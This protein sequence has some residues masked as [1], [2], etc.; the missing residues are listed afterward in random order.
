MPIPQEQLFD[1]V[2]PALLSL[3]S[4]VFIFNKDVD[5]RAVLNKIDRNTAT[6][7]GYLLLGISYFFDILSIIGVP[8]VKSIVSFTYYLKFI[9]SMCFLFSPSLRNYFVIAIVYFGLAAEALRGAV[10]IDFFVW[11]TYFFLVASLRYGLALKIR[12]LFIVLAIPLI[13]VVQSV[14]VEYRNATWTGKQK[15]GIGLFKEL[16]EKKQKR[17]NDPFE[18]SEGV[19]RTVGRLNQGW[20]LGL[21]L[22]WVPRKV[23]FS[24]G[25]DF[26]GDLEG[27]LLPRIFFPEK[28][29]IGSQDKFYKYTGH[30]L[31]NTT[32]MTIG[33]LGDF[34]INFGRTGSFIALFVFGAI[35]SRILYL[36]LKKHVLNN[37]INII[38]IPFLFSYLIRANNDF[39]VV[40]NSF[41]KGYLLFLA[42]SFL[43][44]QFWP[45]RVV[46]DTKL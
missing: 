1:Y 25:E 13:I 3:F 15:S 28:K 18:K 22:R 44:R 32:A 34:Y 19:V 26:K 14:K 41:V 16:T 5:L 11:S 24:D 27:T 6:T 7:L 4:G 37:P 2:I 42:I 23:N 8:G 20:H 29:V 43:H 38:W 40:L 31:H 17:E 35:V 9:G 45:S 21:V 33:V 46:H 36:F 39:Y 12:S 10:F 30:K